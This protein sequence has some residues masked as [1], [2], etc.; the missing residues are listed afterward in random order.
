MTR[1]ILLLL[2]FLAVA[3]CGGSSST[4][5]GRR[6]RYD[7]FSRRFG[8]A[9][10]AGDFVAAYAMTSERHYRGSNDLAAF[11]DLFDRAREEYGEATHFAV[12]YN[13]LEADGPL[14]EDLDFPD[15]VK[16]KDRR[17]RL[18]VTMQEG[19]DESS[20]IYEVW[21]NVVDEGDGD[22]IVTV[23]IPGINM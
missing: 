6:P 18:V 7:A 16:V 23:E 10:V 3:S 14:G 22:R 13:T 5:A 19:P 20:A 8:Q 21:L 1:G 9:I 2:A 17:A 4:E 11:R 12:S 15:A